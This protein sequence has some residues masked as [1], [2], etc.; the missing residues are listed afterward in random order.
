MVINEF[1]NGKS[2]NKPHD[3]DHPKG[4][5]FVEGSILAPDGQVR[6]FDAE[7]FVEAGVGDDVDEV[8]G[9]RRT[10]EVP[11]AAAGAASSGSL[12]RTRV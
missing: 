12:G 2:T 4:Y 7:E 8:G 6:A 1:E 9:T 11:D 10:R 3:V 5:H